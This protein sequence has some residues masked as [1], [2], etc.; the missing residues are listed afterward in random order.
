MISRL[1]VDCFRVA[2]TAEFNGINRD[3]RA[4]RIR[5]LVDWVQRCIP[6]VSPHSMIPWGRLRPMMPTMLPRVGPGRAPGVFNNTGHGHL[7]WALSAVTAAAIGEVVEQALR[8]V[9]VAA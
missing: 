9:A 7:G 5:P 3:S 8:P 1:G 4:D 2:G 6:G